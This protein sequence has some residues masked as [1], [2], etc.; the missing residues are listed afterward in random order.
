MTTIARAH[1][2]DIYEE[3]L[4]AHEFWL[5][6][7]KTLPSLNKIFCISENGA[8]YLRK[9]YK[10]INVKVSR[11][12]VP[13]SNLIP[14]SGDQGLIVVISCSATVE[15]KRTDLIFNALVKFTETNQQRIHWHHIGGGP[16]Q[17]ELARKA[18]ICPQSLK[19]T[20]HGFVQ[21]SELPELY[22]KI[23]PDLFINLSDY[24]GIPVTIM[25]AQSF[26]IPCIARAVGGI[27][28][29][30]S[31]EN[32]VLLS[33]QP[34]LIEIVKGMNSLL[35]SRTNKAVSSLENQ[36]DKFNAE[37]NYSAFALELQALIKN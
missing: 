27:P 10:L 29:I 4:P 33:A 3:R 28:E 18:A 31:A 9:K 35:H 14:A 34:D 19:V 16:L 6:R 24:E 21:N 32:G 20:L 25:E 11:L 13:V 8:S 5:E 26:G 1:G 36:R 30:I 17:S 15:L 23:Q 12:G 2:Y 22:R 37:K 7:E